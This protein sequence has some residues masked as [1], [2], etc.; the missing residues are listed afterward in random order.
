MY[1]NRLLRRGAALIITMV[2][3]AIIGVVAATALAQILRNRQQTRT[4]LIRQQADLLID[5]VLRNAEIRR[6]SDTEFSGETITLGPDQQPFHGTFRITT[7]YQDDR[8]V[9]EIE[10]SENEIRRLIRHSSP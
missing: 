7:R 9:A 5:D 6:K 8:F 3:L 2:L 1:K 10:Y 4:D